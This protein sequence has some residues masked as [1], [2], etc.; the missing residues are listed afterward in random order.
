M[1]FS[2]SPSRITLT[3]RELE[4]MTILWNT[5]EPLI[6]SEIARRGNQLTI[7]TV[8]AL[9][10][11]LLKAGYIEVAE[12]V[13]SGTVLC[14]SYRP[15]I[16]SDDYELGNIMNAYQRI[17]DKSRGIS[18]FVSAFLGEED[19][20]GLLLEEIDELQELLRQKEQELKNRHTEE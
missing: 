7:N 19:N 10:K 8:Q 3:K 12:I 5:T 4:I 18:L 9:L 15:A 2:K 13:Y 6:A 1:H 17:K 16:T 14:R 11:K 20:S